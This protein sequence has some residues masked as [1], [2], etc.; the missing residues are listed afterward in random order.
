VVAE[1]APPLPPP[2]PPAPKPA[3]EKA[4][5]EPVVKQAKAPAGKPEGID[6]SKLP[7]VQQP[8][9]TP[10]EFRARKKRKQ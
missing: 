2:P 7:M 10:E 8:W 3:V 1:A 5:A 9:E 4:K 6:E